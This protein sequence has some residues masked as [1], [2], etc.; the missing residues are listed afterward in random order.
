M[1]IPVAS[2]GLLPRNDGAVGRARFLNRIY[3]KHYNVRV[4]C[5][6]P[7]SGDVYPRTNDQ[8]DTQLGI[9]Y[10]GLS[11]KN[12]PNLLMCVEISGSDESSNHC[13]ECMR[14]GGDTPRTA[15]GAAKE[16]LGWLDQ[17]G[18]LTIL[19]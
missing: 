11:N 16:G 3:Y 8:G 17:Q 18:K 2:P 1:P 7:R 10:M 12:S 6:K 13:N 19:P 9:S 4:Q 15:E 14:A 5:I